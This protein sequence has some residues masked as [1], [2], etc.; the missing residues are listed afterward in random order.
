MFHCEPEN[1]HL[2]CLLKAVLSSILYSRRKLIQKVFK[3]FL[4]TVITSEGYISLREWWWRQVIYIYFDDAR[5]KDIKINDWERLGHWEIRFAWKSSKALA[6]KGL[7]QYTGKKLVQKVG[8]PFSMER[9]T[10]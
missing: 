8:K 10:K 5:Y 9:S 7:H 1:S 4:I 6:G 3:D 2:Q